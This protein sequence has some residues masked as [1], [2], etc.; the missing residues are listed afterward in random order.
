M[1]S[2]LAMLGLLFFL[3][4]VLGASVEVILEVFRRLLEKFGVTWAKSKVSLDDALKRASE[5][6]PDEKDLHTKLQAVKSAAH[7]KL[8]WKAAL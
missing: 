6:A 8:V 2:L 4:L 5:F 3:F 7:A 1:E